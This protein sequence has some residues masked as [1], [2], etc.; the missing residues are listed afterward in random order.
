MANLKWYGPQ[1]LKQIDNGINKNLEKALDFYQEETKSLLNKQGGSSRPGEPPHMQSGDLRDS[2]EI[3][4]DEGN[5]TAIIGTDL[6]YAKWLELGT[7]H[8]R[9]RPFLSVMFQKKLNQLMK[10]VGKEIK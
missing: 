8:I 6:D 10:L 1:V 2:I 3:S 4:V 7:Q 5:N 9:R